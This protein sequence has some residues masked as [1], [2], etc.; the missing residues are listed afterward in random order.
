MGQSVTN[1]MQ[2]LALR[3]LAMQAGNQKWRSQLDS[4]QQPTV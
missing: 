3:N 4:N 1:L 2:L